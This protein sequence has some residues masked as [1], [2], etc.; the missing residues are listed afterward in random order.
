MRQR[1][2]RALVLS[3]W[4]LTRAIELLAGFDADGLAL[5]RTSR[6]KVFLQN[7]EALIQRAQQTAGGFEALQQALAK[8]GERARGP[9]W[10]VAE[11]L[12]G[13]G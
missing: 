6:L 5:Q 1:F 11:W 9:I 8:A 13:R 4:D 12:K 7:L 2:A 10:A 3:S